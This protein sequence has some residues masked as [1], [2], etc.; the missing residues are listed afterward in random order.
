VEQRGI[1][2]PATGAPNVV[3]RREADAKQTTQNDERRREVSASTLPVE[4][5]LSVALERTAAVGRWDV[6]AQL[7]RELEA[8][9]LAHDPKVVPPKATRR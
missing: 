5:A 6:V 8:R 4:V 7:A 2:H 9:R 3:N 1:E